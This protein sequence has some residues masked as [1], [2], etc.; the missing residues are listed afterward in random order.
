MANLVVYTS[1]STIE[2]SVD[3]DEL[4]TSEFLLNF[5]G[6][7]G[8]LDEE[9]NT[10]NLGLF[11]LQQSHKDRLQTIVQHYSKKVPRVNQLESFFK[12]IPNGSH[13]L[14]YPKVEQP[15]SVSLQTI[16]LLRFLDSGLSMEEAYRQAKDEWAWI[17]NTFGPL[18]GSYQISPISSEKRYYAGP[19]QKSD[20][21]C[22]YCGRT[23]A[24]GASFDQEAHTV[25][26]SIGNKVYFTHDE[27]DTC[28]AQFSKTIDLDFFE[29]F[30]IYR[31]P[32]NGRGKHG[33]PTL[34]FED[35]A[36]IRNVAGMPTIQSQDFSEIIPGEKYHLQLKNYSTLNK[37]N[38]YRQLA[39]FA[40]GLANE[41]D[42]QFFSQTANW[43]LNPK[44]DGTVW[45]VP[46]VMA[47]VL[48]PYQEQ[49]KITLYRRKNENAEFPFLFAEVRIAQILLVFIVP[50]S[51]K[52][53]VDFSVKANF[54]NFWKKCQHY[55]M[56]KS[57]TEL[58]LSLDKALKFNFSINLEKRNMPD[59]ES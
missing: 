14:V 18:I 39:K 38:V 4:T 41:E 22:R 30:K 15:F 32:F 29:Y 13:C 21:T 25:P 34:K 3:G 35:G 31:V 57:W 49:P 59:A 16:A 10:I 53:N 12:K 40:L 58:D 50:F 48:N 2:F 43:I 51:S 56:L 28:N 24:T 54:D 27:C 44:N 37:S 45:T 6:T 7:F 55:Q 9:E 17:E 26:E 52:D 20:R 19:R 11:Q 47:H 42:V 8:N 36:E 46:R 5:L 23:T 33:V 1:I